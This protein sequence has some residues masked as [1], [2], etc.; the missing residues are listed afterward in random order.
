MG[1]PLRVIGTTGG[2][3]IQIAIDGTAAIDCGV[4]EAEQLW[5][6]ALA[7]YFESRAA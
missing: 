1:V 5:S 3:R 7:R 2:S 6:T 4:A